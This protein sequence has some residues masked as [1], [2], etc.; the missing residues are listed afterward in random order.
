MI[1]LQSFLLLADL[2]NILGIIVFLLFLVLWVIGQIAEANKKAAARINRPGAP[3][4][5]PEGGGVPAGQQADSLR[6]QMEEFLRRS[7]QAGKQPS[8]IENQQSSALA[9]R[10]EILLD[11]SHVVRDRKPTPQ[12]HPSPSPAEKPRP[13]ARQRTK[14][15]RLASQVDAKLKVL[16]PSASLGQ[17]IIEEDKQFDVQLNA[18]FDHELGSL[19]TDRSSASQPQPTESQDVTSPA[20]LVAAMLASPD[21]ARQ[22]IIL[23][24]VLRRPT[25]LW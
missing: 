7:Q 13:A 23:N 15:R 5:P 8:V 22:A 20:A 10:I 18:K 21:G 19:G 16:T 6:Q 3:P 4:R 24:E 2:G 25:E 17:R 9:D 12:Q 11:D 14:S 1:P